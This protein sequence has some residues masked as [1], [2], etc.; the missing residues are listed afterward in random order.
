MLK[1][2]IDISCHGSASR[3]PSL[4]APSEGGAEGGSGNL[5]VVADCVAAVGKGV[6]VDMV[7]AGI[8]G[9]VD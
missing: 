6:S 9:D 2:S 1:I 7:D 4:S 8:I 3:S 5:I